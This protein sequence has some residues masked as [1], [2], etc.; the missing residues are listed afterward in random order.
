MSHR[1]CLFMAMNEKTRVHIM[2]NSQTAHFFLVPYTHT[3]TTNRAESCFKTIN[4]IN[5][6]TR[7]WKLNKIINS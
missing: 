1:Q 6:Q 7:V 3:I 5:H 4:S 2:P